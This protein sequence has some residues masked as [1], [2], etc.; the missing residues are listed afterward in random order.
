MSG[1]DSDDDDDVVVLVCVILIDSYSRVVLVLIQLG[2]LLGVRI[3]VFLLN[4]ML[5][6]R[7]IVVL[8]LVELLC[9]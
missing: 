3:A 9:A 8:R 7:L 1:Y 4:S 2:G 5:P 6:G